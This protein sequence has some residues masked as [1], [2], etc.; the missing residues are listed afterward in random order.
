M[1]GLISGGIYKIYPLF[2][3]LIEV[4]QLFL[5]CFALVLHS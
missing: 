1:G 5:V 4:F 3:V 2:H